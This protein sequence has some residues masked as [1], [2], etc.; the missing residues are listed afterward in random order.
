MAD[1]IVKTNEQIDGATFG[2][3][4]FPQTARYNS[5]HALQCN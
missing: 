2:K 4:A 1:K 5:I 3:F